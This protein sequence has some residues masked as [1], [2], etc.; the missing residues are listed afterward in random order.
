MHLQNV[1]HQIVSSLKKRQ[2]NVTIVMDVILAG[3][4]LNKIT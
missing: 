2:K 4:E 3:E 1:F